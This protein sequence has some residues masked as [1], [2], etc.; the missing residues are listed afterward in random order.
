MMF[1]DQYGGLQT[2]IKNPMKNFLTLNIANAIQN[3]VLREQDV[4]VVLLILDGKMI[5]KK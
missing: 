2:K 3:M 1:I 5:W 4:W